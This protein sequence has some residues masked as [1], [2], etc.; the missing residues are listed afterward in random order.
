MLPHFTYHT[1]QVRPLSATIHFQIGG[2]LLLI[3]TV[4]SFATCPLSPLPSRP[5]MQSTVLFVA[6]PLAAARRRH[7][8]RHPQRR[9]PAHLCGPAPSRSETSRTTARR[10]DARELMRLAAPSYLAQVT[11]PVA[12]LADLY[13]IGRLGALPVAG[14]AVASALFNTFCYTFTGLAYS[15]NAHVAAQRTHAGAERA[16]VA[17]ARVAVYL[18]AIVALLMYFLAPVLVKAMKAAA[19]T[20]GYAVA[21]LRTR[22][23]GLPFMLLTFALSGVFRARRD[24][25]RPLIASVLAAALNAALDAV[26]VPVAGVPGAGVATAIAA[27]AG[28]VYLVRAL[29]RDG[30]VGRNAML[31]WKVKKSDARAIMSPLIPLSAKRVM[32]SCAIAVCCAAAASDGAPAAAAMEIAQQVWWTVG[33][34]WWPIGV[35]ASA[36]IAGVVARDGG[37]RARAIDVGVMSLSVVA[38][39]AFIGASIVYITAGRIPALFVREDVY[40]QVSRYAVQLL[41]LI[42]PLSAMVDLCDAVLVSIGD[43]KF[44]FMATSAGVLLCFF[45]LYFIKPAGITTVFLALGAMTALQA[46]LVLSRFA[47][48]WHQCRKLL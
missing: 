27:M 20:G 45:I 3:S 17:A 28:A 19:G 38:I 22:A 5:A 14:V 34:L 21:Y 46:V 47:I 43:A 15:T 16:A 4:P 29:K 42:L 25:K 6:S 41:A 33:V 44:V 8:R 13:F 26:L 7:V 23:I 31:R 10:E 37:D 40:I 18:G 48:F 9:R 30:V 32:E 35:A 11:E 24:L 1:L 12:A 39:L 2:A 36:I